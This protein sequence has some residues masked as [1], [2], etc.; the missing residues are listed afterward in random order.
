MSKFKIG[1]RVV[2]VKSPLPNRIGQLATIISDLKLKHWTDYPPSIRRLMHKLDL[3][4]NVYY[5]PCH[6]E[7]YKDDGN[8]KAEWTDELTKLCK[9]KETVNV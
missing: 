1:D 9:L 4:P 7:L 5:P 3:G 2:I 8:E 6:L